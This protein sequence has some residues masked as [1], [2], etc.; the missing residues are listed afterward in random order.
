M[1]QPYAPPPATP[2]YQPPQQQAGTNTLA[3]V[4]LIASLFVSLA[5][6]ICGHIALSQ[7]KKTGQ[8]GRGL[9]LAGTIIGYVIMGLS[10][11]FVIGYVIFF[12]VL[13]G[14]AGVTSSTFS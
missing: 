7:I 11:L 8:S 13:I 6:V 14:T 12:V 9:A 3:I 4:A 5:G 1:T 10:V 2:A